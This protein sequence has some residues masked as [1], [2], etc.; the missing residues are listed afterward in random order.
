MKLLKTII[1]VILLAVLLPGEE[2]VTIT[3]PVDGEEWLLGSTQRFM[4]NSNGY[5]GTIMI[6]IG[7]IDG[8][9]DECTL[10][11]GHPYPP[12]SSEFYEWKVG[13]TGPDRPAL[14]PGEY[15][16]SIYHMGGDIDGSWSSSRRFTIKSLRIEL[17]RRQL[18]HIRYRLPFPHDPCRCPEFDLLPLRETL[19]DLKS[20]LRIVLLKNGHQVQQLGN[21]ASASRLPASL[22]AQLSQN[23]FDLLKNGQAKFTLAVLGARNKIISQFELQASGPPPLKRR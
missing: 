19:T 2:E 5:T 14:S 18:F 12:A 17:P 3:S 23:D 10:P 6:E 15:S 9:L 1:L 11:P 4:W 22:K 21:F 7:R 13:D 16:F 20:P 8:G